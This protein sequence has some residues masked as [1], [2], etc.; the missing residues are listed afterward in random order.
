MFA[1]GGQTF[2]QL[3]RRKK[4]D[5]IEHAPRRSNFARSGLFSKG[6]SGADGAEKPLIGKYCVCQAIRE[7]LLEG[8]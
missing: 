6:V 8:V 3:D 5:S 7:P 2:L 1:A 4:E